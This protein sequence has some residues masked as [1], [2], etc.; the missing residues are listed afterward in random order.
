MKKVKE[1][2]IIQLKKKNKAILAWFEYQIKNGEIRND[3]AIKHEIEEESDDL[4]KIENNF[5]KALIKLGGKIGERVNLW[6]CW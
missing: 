6:I 2:D 4:D 5:N 3:T 1:F